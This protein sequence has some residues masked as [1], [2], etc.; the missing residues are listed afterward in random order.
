M[1]PG[2]ACCDQRDH[3][4]DAHAFDVEP[5]GDQQRHHQA[6]AEFVVG[7]EK[8]RRDKADNHA[9]QRA[10]QRHHQ[11]ESCEMLGRGLHRRQFA[12]EEHAHH[13]QARGEQRYR[14]L[15]LHDAAFFVHVPSHCTHHHDQWPDKVQALVP[16]APLEAQDE[17]DEVQR[18]RQQPQ[19]GH[20]GN[21]VCDEV[22]H[23]QQHERAHGR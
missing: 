8:L 9:A 22:G 23:R 1:K 7:V 2:E 6:D 18:Q 13:E 17:G 3:G 4:H 21:V 5:R 16:V 19:E 14:D 20:R 15:E 10:A 11:K 12:V